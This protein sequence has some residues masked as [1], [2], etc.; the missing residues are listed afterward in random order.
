MDTGQFV[1]LPTAIQE[2]HCEVLLLPAIEPWAWSIEAGLSSSGQAQYVTAS[3]ERANYLSL[4]SRQ[5]L[6]T[7]WSQDIERHGGN[8]RI[9]FEMAH[10]NFDFIA[11]EEPGVVIQA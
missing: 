3:D 11:A 2:P 9:R 8:L 6:R 7:I 4:F 5:G 10:G 1:N